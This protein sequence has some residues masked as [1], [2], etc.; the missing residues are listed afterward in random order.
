MPILKYTLVCLLLLS[1]SLEATGSNRHRLSIG[2][3]IYHVNRI[4]H[5]GTVQNGMLYGVRANYDYL[6]RYLLYFGLDASYA[7]GTLK[8]KSGNG[9]KLKSHFSDQWCEARFGYTFQGLTGCKA[10]FTPFVGIGGAWEFNNYASPSPVHLHFRNSYLYFAVGC[11]TQAMIRPWFTVGANIT[12]KYSLTGKMRVSRDPD[13]ESIKLPYEQMIHCRV[14]LPITYAFCIN[15][16]EKIFSLVPFFE[17]RHYGQQNGFPFDFLD[18]KIRIW[19]AEL[20]FQ[21]YF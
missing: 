15:G 1:V 6:G 19:G 14:G 12:A 3:E 7:Y 18:T 17:Y 8:G 10:M 21:A 20:L 16:D 5:G 2:P 11:L 9:S 4:R 13:V